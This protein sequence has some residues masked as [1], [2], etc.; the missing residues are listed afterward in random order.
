MNSRKV[1]SGLVL[2]GIL[3]LVL[4]WYDGGEKPLREIVQPVALPGDIE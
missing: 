1:L 2:I 4:A 3:L